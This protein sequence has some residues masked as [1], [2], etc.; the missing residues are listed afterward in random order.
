MQT[1]VIQVSFFCG[2]TKILCDE[3][4][5]IFFSEYRFKVNDYDN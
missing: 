1:A 4:V 2:A 3:N 5:N